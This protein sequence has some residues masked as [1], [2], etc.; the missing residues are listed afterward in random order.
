MLLTQFLRLLMTY[1]QSRDIMHIFYVVTYTYFLLLIVQVCS[2]KTGQ[3]VQYSSLKNAKSTGISSRDCEMTYCSSLK[4]SHLLK[5][6]DVRGKFLKSVQSS[7]EIRYC[8]GGQSVIAY[9]SSR[10]ASFP[11][12]CLVSQVNFQFSCKVQLLNPVGME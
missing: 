5:F 9:M 3:N 6:L 4:F 2:T 12:G 1:L 8:H 10:V 7:P 11:D